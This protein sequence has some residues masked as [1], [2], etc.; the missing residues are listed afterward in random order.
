MNESN[1]ENTDIDIYSMGNKAEILSSLLKKMAHPERLMVLCQLSLGEMA[2][3]ELQKRTTLSQ[4]AF[5]QHLAVLREQNIVMARKEAHQVYY[6]LTDEKVKALLKAMH[7]IFCAE[8]KEEN[9]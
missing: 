5:S 9:K 2:V 7:Q 4:S 8:E 6:S 3:G 1:K